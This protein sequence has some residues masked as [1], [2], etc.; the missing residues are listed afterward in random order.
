MFLRNCWYAA[1]FS[2]ELG[3][4][5][6]ARTF[7]GETVVMYRQEDVGMYQAQQEAIDGD[8][9]GSTP[10]NVGAQVTIK[11]DEGLNQ[12]RRIIQRMLKEEASAGRKKKHPKAAPRRAAA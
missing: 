8:P 3:R 10:E 11:Y 7:L 5:F 2:E 1:G 12:A 4:E 6:L 9:A